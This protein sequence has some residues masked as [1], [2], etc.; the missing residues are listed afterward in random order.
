MCGDNLSNSAKPKPN[1]CILGH[2]W[3][4]LPAAPPEAEIARDRAS[5]GLS[6]RGHLL[7]P[8]RPEL[9][10]RSVIPMAELVHHPRGLIVDLA[11]QVV[12]A[13]RP[14]TTH[15]V[16][17]LSLSDET[18]MVT[19]VV[20]PPIYARYRTVLRG[21]VVLWI[22]G[23]LERRGTALSVRAKRISSLTALLSTTEASDMRIQRSPLPPCGE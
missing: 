15:G 21:E 22:R 13:Q 4:A 2:A 9:T 17:F 5:L 10:R 3:V 20:L 19:V 8:L 23:V 6:L 11:G 7:A 18:G 14:G 1:G 12:S 16:L